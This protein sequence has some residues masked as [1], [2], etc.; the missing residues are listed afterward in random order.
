MAKLYA[1]ET[2]RELGRES[3]DLLGTDEWQS[4]GEQLVEDYFQSQH[5]TIAAGT[6]EIQR[7]TIARTMLELPSSKRAG[8]MISLEPQLSDEEA[9]LLGAGATS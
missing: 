6:S 7:N 2:W 9:D 3:V 4:L 8:V 5:Y 1:S